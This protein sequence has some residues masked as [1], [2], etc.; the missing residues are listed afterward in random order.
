MITLVLAFHNHQPVGNFGWVIEEAYQKSYLPLM[1]IMGR[2]PSIRFAQHYTGILLDWFEANHPDFIARIE[3]EVATG[4]VELLS[5]GYYEPIM[6]MLP[7]RDRQAQITKL[8]AR[9]EREF[10]TAP[11][12][13]WL[14]ERVWEPSLPSTLHDAG[15]RYTILDDTHFKSAGLA[16]DDLTGYFLTED[17]G[18]PLAVLPIDKRLRYTMP[19]EKPEATF[20]YLKTL[21][22][23]GEDRVVVF[24]DDGE[25]FGT[26][27]DT[28]RTVYEE[29][30][31]DSFCRLLVANSSWLRTVPPGE[32]VRTMKP[33]GRLYLPTA[34]Y[35]EML[36]WALP[37]AEAFTEYEAFEHI[38][39]DEKLLDEYGSFVRGGF[40]RN[41][42]VKYPEVNA[43]QKK[44]LR[45]SERIRRARRSG[46]LEALGAAESAIGEAYDHLMAA[47]CNCPYWHGVFGGLYLSNIRAAIYRE[48]I[49]AERKLDALEGIA[50]G[51]V[52]LTDYDVDGF[53][54]MIYE[55]PAINLYISPERGGTIFEFDYKPVGYNFSDL[56][57]RRREGYH[58]QLTRIAPAAGEAAKP[59]VTADKDGDDDGGARSIHDIVRVKEEGLERALIYDDYRHA[60]LV[61]HFLDGEV[62]AEG[63][64]TGTL[65]EIGDF[66]KGAYA[67]SSARK[68]STTLLTLRREGTLATGGRVAVEKAVSIEDGSADI[69]VSYDVRSL[70]GKPLNG[71]FAIEMAYTMSAGTEPDRYYE[72]DGRKPPENDGKL[73]GTG[74]S[75]G[76]SWALVDEWLGVRIAVEME[77]PGVILRAPVETV[78]LS[79][80]GF[81]R[82][83]QGSVVMM[84]W[85]LEG[86]TGW[87]MS[88]TQR[89]AMLR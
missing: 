44:M 42:M 49:T 10:G 24:A 28:Y 70:D 55:S 14:A 78:S 68:G 45:V 20:D 64:R 61:D 82:N 30:W 25:K 47:Q 37:T 17:Q 52:A 75:P 15:I 77:R 23:E 40:W 67:A 16:E 12:G 46:E 69:R 13:M 26:W 4:R 9:I 43:M 29:G 8:N 38:L 31:L 74:E 51:S 34:S 76:R 50:A 84:A 60:M 2:Y 5:G 63:L 11:T 22:R 57:Q 66:V 59:A 71:R 35:A 53:E 36:H 19:F 54:E 1:R 41:F 88:F 87:T 62:S 89:I 21:D 39:K 83:Y 32:V 58:A 6:A 3:G 73:N 7:E 18:K 79:E 33:A 48:L 72:I 65:A 56:L 81:E 80:E 27:P 86:A 85:D